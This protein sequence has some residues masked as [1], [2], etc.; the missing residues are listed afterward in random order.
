MKFP[1]LGISVH[2]LKFLLAFLSGSIIY[3]IL[4]NESIHP[5]DSTPDFRNELV[6][7]SQRDYRDA[8]H[9]FCKQRNLHLNKIVA[10]IETERSVFKISIWIN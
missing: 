9:K 5:I 10:D 8:E 2:S 3:I 6:K 1:Q 4:R 7:V